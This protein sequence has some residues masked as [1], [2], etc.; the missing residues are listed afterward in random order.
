MEDGDGGDGTK[1]ID[2]ELGDEMGTVDW[3]KCW[4][5][6]KVT[7]KHLETKMHWARR[8]GKIPMMRSDMLSSELTWFSCQCTLFLRGTSSVHFD[9]LFTIQMFQ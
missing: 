3:I 4:M 5:T 1:P 6:M 2:N 7:L 9:D 8:T